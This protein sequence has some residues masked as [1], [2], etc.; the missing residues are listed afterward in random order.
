MLRKKSPVIEPGTFRLVAQRLNHNATPGPI[1]N[2]F[3][4]NNIMNNATLSRKGAN[5]S[6]R[7]CVWMEE[8]ASFQNNS[9]TGLCSP[10]STMSD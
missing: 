2:S 1:N 9:R 6:V 8:L 3:I 10:Y 4:S 7:V 5:Y